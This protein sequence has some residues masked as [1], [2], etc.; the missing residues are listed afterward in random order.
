MPSNNL[1]DFYKQNAGDKIW[2][3]AN[4]NNDDDELFFSFDRK[5]LYNLFRDYPHRLTKEQKAIFDKENPFWVEFFAG[6]QP[7]K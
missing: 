6:K 2:W 1:C 3:A 7:K 5:T 4:Y